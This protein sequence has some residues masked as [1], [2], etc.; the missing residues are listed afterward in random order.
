M[1][2]PQR[3]ALFLQSSMNFFLRVGAKEAQ[4]QAPVLSNEYGDQDTF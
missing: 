3:M 4:D 2:F 1:D